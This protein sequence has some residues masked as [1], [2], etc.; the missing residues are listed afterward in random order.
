MQAALPKCTNVNLNQGELGRTLLHY[1]AIGGHVEIVKLLLEDPR[2]DVRAVDREKFSALQLAA[3]LGHVEVVKLLLEDPRVDVRA[4]D[5]DGWSA[6]HFAASSGHD[7]MVSLLL[8]DK[9]DGNAK[10]KK[11]NTPLHLAAS[12]NHHKVVRMLL[13]NPRLSIANC[14]DNT[15]QCSP[16]MMALKT[17]S[18]A[19]LQELLNHPRVSLGT[20]DGTG[21]SL[22]MVARWVL[23]NQIGI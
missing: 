7:E 13:D 9:A 14:A 11:G 4:V 20:I 8:E 1:A 10:T 6:L 23:Y 15:L 17:K 3:D 19:A 16:V 12:S 18:K 5:K 22:E 21:R 2:V